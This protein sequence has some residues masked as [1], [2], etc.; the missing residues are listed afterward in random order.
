MLDLFAFNA[1]VRN[2]ML[3]AAVGATSHVELQLLIESRQ[4]FFKFINQP[5]RKT[6]GLR[7]GQLAELSPCAGDSAAPE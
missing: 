5:A 3:A 2:P 6:L 7:D 4:P 1:D